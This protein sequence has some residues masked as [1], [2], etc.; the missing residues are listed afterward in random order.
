MS[1]GR[2]SG[3]GGGQFVVA[4]ELDALQHRVHQRAAH[5]R[6]RMRVER[7]DSFEQWQA[8]QRR[9]RPEVRRVDEGHA[10]ADRLEQV[11]VPAA[12]VRACAARSASRPRSTNHRRTHTPRHYLCVPTHWSQ[13][14]SAWQRAVHGIQLTSA[15][16]AGD[17]G[18]MPSARLCARHARHTQ[19]RRLRRPR[20]RNRSKQA[21][22]RSRARRSSLRRRGPAETGK[23][24]PRKARLAHRACSVP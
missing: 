10:R 19:S 23:P 5:L 17:C 21:D 9:A 12:D 6:Q 7:G 18:G 24:K 13:Q 15:K 8:R 2:A 3:S 1:G 11:G 4:R 22:V 20:G 16:K 14:R